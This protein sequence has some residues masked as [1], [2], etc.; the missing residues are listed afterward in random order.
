MTPNEVVQELLKE[1]AF[2]EYALVSEIAIA[3]GVITELL[4]EAYNR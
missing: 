1:L 2:G 3:E 4:M